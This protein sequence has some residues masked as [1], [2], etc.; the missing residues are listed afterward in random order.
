MQA[1]CD[2]GCF[3]FAGLARTGGRRRYG[4]ALARRLRF[5][6]ALINREETAPLKFEGHLILAFSVAEFADPAFHPILPLDLE[7][8]KGIRTPSEP[9]GELALLR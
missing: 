8:G 9:S 5:D 3:I 7:C 2:G 1:T 4:K 6:R